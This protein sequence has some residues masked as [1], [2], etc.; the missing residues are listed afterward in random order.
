MYTDNQH[1]QLSTTN[2]EAAEHYRQALAD[3][4]EY[5]LS[6]GKSA[7]AAVAADP[8]FVLGH[9]L[10]GYF[11]MLIGS[12]AF[13]DG[14]REHL[15][16]AKRGVADVTHREQQHVL[17]LETWLD[18]DVRRCCQIWA[19]IVT[20]HPH[21]VLALRLHHFASFWRGR[22]WDL[23][24]L[25]AQ[26]LSAWDENMPGYGNVLG[27]LAFGHEE[28][29]DLNDAETLGREAVSLNPDDLW[30]LHAVAHVLE[31]QGRLEEGINWL[32]YPAD[33]WQ[34]RNPFRGHLWWH[35][36]LYSHELGDY[37]QVLELYDR[38]IRVEKNAFYLDIQNQA[39]LLMR[40]EFQGVDIGQRWVELADYLEKFAVEEEE[41]A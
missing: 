18:G 31:M 1:L 2:A 40:L 26:V 28:C 11:N 24:A 22:Q 25:P 36:A 23:R 34:D 20:D 6:A 13:Y 5:R 38:S 19:G 35:R 12:R 16:L 41:E 8:E 4:F 15:Q 29:G 9:C 32:N 33:H 37:D 17:A 10:R 14:A 21:D 7:K 27:M 3:Y 30:A 39:S